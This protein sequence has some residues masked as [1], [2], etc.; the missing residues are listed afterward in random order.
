MILSDHGAA[1]DD[2]N[3]AIDDFGMNR[4]DGFR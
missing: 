4:E 3:A 1:D 2:I